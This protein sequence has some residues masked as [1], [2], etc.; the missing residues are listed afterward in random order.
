VGGSCCLKY[1]RGMN[2]FS[3]FEARKR[4]VRMRCLGWVVRDVLWR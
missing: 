1:S 3:V 2:A 4:V